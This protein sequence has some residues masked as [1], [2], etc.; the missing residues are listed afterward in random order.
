MLSASYGDIAQYTFLRMRNSE[1]KSQVQT[2]GQELTTGR[3]SNVTERLGGDFTYLSG[4]EHSLSKLGSYQVAVTEVTV[5]AVSIQSSLSKVNDNVQQTRDDIVTLTSSLSVP[6]AADLA[7]DS[8]LQLANSIDALNASVG[9]RSLFAGTAT[10]SNALNS[11]DTLMSALAT[12]IAGLTTANDVRAAIENWFDDPTGFDT[13]MYNG[14]ANALAPIDVGSNDQVAL[15]ALANDPAFKQSLMGFALAA[16]TEEPGVTLNDD[17]KGNLVRMAGSQL[18]VGNDS[19]IQLQSDVGFM[20]ERIESARTRNEAEITSL[21]ITKN[22]MLEADPYETFSK[23]EEA[24]NQL[25]SLYVVTQ[26]SFELTL[27]RYIS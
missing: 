26:K 16:I 14:S 22:K 1:L 4:I 10:K 11:A 15:D 17:V 12:E 19:L 6:V 21:S 2:L 9:G 18:S 23:L 7:D 20:Q 24:Q 5:L 8:R 13:V 27:L 25:E 3:T